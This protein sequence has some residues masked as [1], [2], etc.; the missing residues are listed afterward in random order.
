[1]LLISEPAAICRLLSRLAG[2]ALPSLVLAV[3][4]S[5]LLPGQAL[6][7]DSHPAEQQEQAGSQQP[8]H[9]TK[10]GSKYS[11]THRLQAYFSQI[12]RQ[13]IA[14][15]RGHPM[16]D[17]S[18]HRALPLRLQGLRLSPYMARASNEL[19]N[20]ASSPQ[21][22]GQAQDWPLGHRPGYQDL[23]LQDAWWLGA[24]YALDLF[25]PLLLQGNLHRTDLQQDDGQRQQSWLADLSLSYSTEL[26]TPSI[27]ARYSRSEHS[28][29]QL[30]Q[31]KTLPMALRNLNF[32]PG[33]LSGPDSPGLAGYS[34][35]EALAEQESQGFYST[36]QWQVGIGIRDISI[37]QGLE[38]SLDL[39][40]G[41]G[42]HN[43]DPSLEP[44]R[45]L[46]S[47][48]SFLEARVDQ[49]YR[50]Y[51]NLAAILELGYASLDLDPEIWGEDPQD[52]AYLMSFGLN[53]E[54]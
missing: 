52:N 38:Y 14:G 26:A 46:S 25:R 19:P 13:H 47:E 34:L 39:T 20:A 31:G 54:F 29:S 21:P 12:S 22:E 35:V 6:S 5:M 4:C 50:I 53:Y 2:K 37:L 45:G 42:T 27:W 30:Q 44:I 41:K 36:G 49:R 15:N 32:T 24:S 18:W 43:Q 10:P 28:G 51:E 40:Y 17:R 3:L 33:M 8:G 16:A 1:M 9:T 11:P 23:D 48:D 7:L